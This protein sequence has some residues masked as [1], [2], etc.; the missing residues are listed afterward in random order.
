MWLNT[1]GRGALLRE[2]TLADGV[3]A[4]LRT[5]FVNGM[6][7]CPSDVAEGARKPEHAE[8]VEVDKQHEARRFEEVDE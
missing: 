1:Y 3:T 8:I 2:V 4:P 7:S 5:W 6:V